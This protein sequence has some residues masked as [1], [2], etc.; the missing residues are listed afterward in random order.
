[1]LGNMVNVISCLVQVFYVVS[2]FP[3][4]LENYKRQSGSG[5]S[6][7]LLF[8][9][10]NGYIA[11][12]YFLHCLGHAP[13]FQILN[14]MQFIALLVLMF[15]RFYYAEQVSALCFAKFFAANSIVAVLLFPFASYIPAIFGDI[16]GWIAAFFFCMSQFFQIGKM[17]VAKSV[18]GMSLF[19]VLF[20][21]FGGVLELAVT[22]IMI[23]PVE[24]RL[25]L[26]RFV[27]GCGIYCVQFIAYRK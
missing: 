10:F 19:F 3:Q 17:Y 22:Y 21:M 7:V 25:S 12:T 14:G 16:S 15:Q 8:G 27:L 1:M 20:M 2:F 9:Y 6:D 5:L 18:V 11:F 24:T 23:S 26:W 13:I 4:I